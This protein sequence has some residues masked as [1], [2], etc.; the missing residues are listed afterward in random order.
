MKYLGYTEK[1]ESTKH[2]EKI[3]EGK[4]S[5]KDKQMIQKLSN[6]DERLCVTGYELGRE[7]SWTGRNT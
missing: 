4:V 6:Y 7:V 2:G 5:D 3:Y 1:M